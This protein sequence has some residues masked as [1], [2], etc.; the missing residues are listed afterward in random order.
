MT[1]DTGSDAPVTSP[2]DTLTVFAEALRDLRLKA[3]NPTLAA[4]SARTGISKSV[5]SVAFNGGGLPT[6][7]TVLE[8]VGALG[9]DQA[10]WRARREALNSRKAVASSDAAVADRGGAERGGPSALGTGTGASRRFT[11][12]QLGLVALVAVVLSAVVTS[13]IWGA[14]G[15]GPGAAPGPP[16]NA[17]GP[18]FTAANGVDPMRT[19]CKDDAVIAV[20]E[21]RFNGQVH[22][23]LLYSNNCFASW[24]R[25][26]RYDGASNG[27]TVSMKIWIEKDPNGKRTQ[28]RTGPNAQSVYTDMII[29][30]DPN[31]RICG[32]ATITADG[33]TLELGPPICG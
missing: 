18:Y 5:L 32:V 30:P 15:A 8:L 33:K 23:Q 25:V 29:E 9:G 4:L 14:V 7:R 31:I 19:K 2:Q 28:Q 16:E 17:S 27:N 3:G 10:E 6:E 13:L 1:T 22:M 12:L 26:T 21:A 11:L 20:D 24:G